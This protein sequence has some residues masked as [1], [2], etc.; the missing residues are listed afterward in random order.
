[1]NEQ[2]RE[3]IIRN[4]KNPSHPTAFSG[5][6]NV[7][8]YYKNRATFSEIKN[9]LSSINAYTLHREYKQL[10]TNP[11]YVQYPRQQVQI[12]LAQVDHLAQDNEGIRYL[13]IVIDAFTKFAWVRPMK[14]KL[15][16]TVLENFISVLQQAKI[17]PRTILC[18]RGNEFVNRLFSAYCVQNNIKLINNYT[19]VHAPIAERFIRTL[20]QMMAK[21]MTSKNTKRYLEELQNIVK[22]YNLRIHRSI[23]MAPYDAE[24]PSSSLDIRHALSKMRQNIKKKPVKYP[25]GQKVRIALERTKFSRGHHRKFSD[26]IFT[27]Y[28]VKTKLPIPIYYI[29][30]ENNE[31]I[32]GGFYAYELTPVIT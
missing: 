3:E 8:K 11:N 13:L 23:K 4:Y 20:K 24:K 1:M 22:S 28:H 26:E 7:Y 19:S 16:N 6:H 15:A 29:K 17:K 12:D 5:I 21:Y 25:I 9:I 31:K 32:S 2:L 27:I 10:A 14:N 18:D 30:D